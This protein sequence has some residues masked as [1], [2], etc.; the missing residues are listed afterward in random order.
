MTV[1]KILIISISANLFFIV[2][3]VLIGNPP[4]Q[5]FSKEA[6]YITWVSFTQMLIIANICWR[7]Y[8]NVRLESDK[9]FWKSPALLW[10][11]VFIGFLYLSLD[12]VIRIHE[13]LDNI[14]HRIFH[15]QKTE[16]SD[17]LD[18]A[19]VG[20]YGLLGIFVLL[21]FNSE[22]KRYKDALMIFGFGFVLFF[23]MVCADMSV[24]S[25][26]FLK[27]LFH[28]CDI[29]LLFSTI[30]ILE[31]SFKLMAEA[32]FISAFYSVF[33]MTKTRIINPFQSNTNNHYAAK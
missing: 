3:G 16:M 30:K 25:T 27:H 6:T 20:L 15:L 33:L 4:E 7:I 32:V 14:I 17:R 22:L 11:L 5:Y 2:I 1:P 23:L 24:N 31:E 26:S 29:S 18:D 12:E 9:S 8:K 10:M 28:G 21:I 19:I 13:N